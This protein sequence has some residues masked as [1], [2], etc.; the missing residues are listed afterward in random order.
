MKAIVIAGNIG[1]NAEIRRTQKG[2]AVTGF[3]V[4]VEDRAGQEKRTLWFDVSMWG[5]RGESLAM[6]RAIPR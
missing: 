5:R 6:C 1:K 4:A 3:S 2:D